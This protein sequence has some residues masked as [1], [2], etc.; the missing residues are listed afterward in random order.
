[1]SITRQGAKAKG[2]NFERLIAKKIGE[3]FN[4]SRTRRTPCSGALPDFK[5]DI[6]CLPDEI[7]DFCFEV[8]CQETTKIWEWLKQAESE[9][10]GRTAVLVFTRNRSK[11]YA[12]LEFGDFLNLLLEARMDSRK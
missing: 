1:M 3:A 4:C 11:E 9:S 12:V 5:G 6:A 10:G 8:K 7:K 2:K